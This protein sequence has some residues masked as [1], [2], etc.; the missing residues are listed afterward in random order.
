[1]RTLLKMPAQKSF[2][3]KNGNGVH[4]GG[5]VSPQDGT[6]SVRLC[7]DVLSDKHGNSVTLDG[8]VRTHWLNRFRQ[9][10]DRFFASWRD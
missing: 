7:D 8:V 4:R 10:V 9:E 1:M 6:E 5:S 3:K 2:A